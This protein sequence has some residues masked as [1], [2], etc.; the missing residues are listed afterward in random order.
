LANKQ[1]ER[2]SDLEEEPIR[3]TQVTLEPRLGVKVPERTEQYGLDP[4][5]PGLSG[6]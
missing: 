2:M 4:L 6:P 3:N 5:F 1:H